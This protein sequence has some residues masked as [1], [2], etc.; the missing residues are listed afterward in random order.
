MPHSLFFE[1][2]LCLKMLFN[3]PWVV[4]AAI[5]G[6]D[7]LRLKTEASLLS[8][9]CLSV[10]LYWLIK[11]C[12]SQCFY[13]EA[14]ILN[15]KQGFLLM[16]KLPLNAW[17]FDEWCGNDQEAAEEVRKAQIHKMNEA[18]RRFYCRL[19]DTAFSPARNT[20]HS[21]VVASPNL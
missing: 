4:D 2:L 7:S 14:A 20:V 16:L 9:S 8:P 15:D 18:G 19:S 1:L 3:V 12:S 6:K 21:I 17:W 11:S 10:P 13:V 5:I